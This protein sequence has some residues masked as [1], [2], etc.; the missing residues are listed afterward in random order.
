MTVIS[1]F[2]SSISER[3]L[4]AASHLT[5][6]ANTCSARP[7]VMCPSDGRATGRTPSRALRPRTR[8]QPATVLHERAAVA[9]DLRRPPRS[10]IAGRPRS[11]PVP[12]SCICR[13]LSR[14]SGL[15]PASRCPGAKR[16]ASTQ[17]RVTR[18]PVEA[19]KTAGDRPDR[20]EVVSL[21][22]PHTSIATVAS[23]LA[24]RDASRTEA[25]MSLARKKRV[26]AEHQK[27]KR[28]RR[29]GAPPSHRRADRDRARAA[30]RADRGRKRR[31]SDRAPTLIRARWAAAQERAEPGT[32]D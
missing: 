6:F 30:R 10:P 16:A 3:T 21:V 15:R 17:G 29:R 26:G 25:T 11:A 22:R 13:L 5:R 23:R 1:S 4:S 9:A 28:H 14:G 2:A 32:T 8:T 20:L 24:T 31:A 27:R 19:L 12:C 7:A 18:R